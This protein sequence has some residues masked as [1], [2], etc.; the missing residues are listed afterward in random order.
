[1]I[2]DR[3]D[4]GIDQNGRRFRRYSKLYAESLEFKLAGKSR[5]DVDLRFTNEMMDSIV[6]TGDGPGYVEIGF[7]NEEARLKMLYNEG[8][9]RSFFGIQQSELDSILVDYPVPQ[10]VSQSLST[11]ILSELLRRFRGN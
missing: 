9:G 3:T 10:T 8:N 5:N 4:Q 6:V 7:D 2:Q 1:M 11:A